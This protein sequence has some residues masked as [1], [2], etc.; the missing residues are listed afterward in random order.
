MSQLK[1]RS[2]S[3]S[4]S[5]TSLANSGEARGKMEVKTSLGRVTRGL[6]RGCP[7]GEGENRELNYK[8]MSDR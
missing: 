7:L 5:P 4:A 1:N 3:L 6:L 8:E 2:S